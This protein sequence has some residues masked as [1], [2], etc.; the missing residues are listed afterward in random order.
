MSTFFH[1][2]VVSFGGADTRLPASYLKRVE[3]RPQDAQLPKASGHTVSTG[4]GSDLPL[5]PAAKCHN[6]HQNLKT[7]GQDFGEGVACESLDRW[8]VGKE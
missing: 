8:D 1:G 3:N 6:C 4:I 7:D 2:H 5:G